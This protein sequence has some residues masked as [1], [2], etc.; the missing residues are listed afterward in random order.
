MLATH[1]EQK[2]PDLK[3]SNNLRFEYLEI[4]YIYRCLYSFLTDISRE[5]RGLV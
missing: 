1:L 5:N 2:S 4:E 3:D